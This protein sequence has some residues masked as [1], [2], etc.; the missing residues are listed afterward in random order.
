M[1]EEMNMMPFPEIVFAFIHRITLE[2]RF[3]TLLR[4]EETMKFRGIR[5]LGGAGTNPKEADSKNRLSILANV[6]EKL[7]FHRSIG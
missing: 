2:R 4:V 6:L 3:K 1:V 7:S 5:F